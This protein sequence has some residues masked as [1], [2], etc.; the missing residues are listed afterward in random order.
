LPFTTAYHTRYPEY[1]A[2]RWPI[3]TWA[4]YAGLR[5]F[6]GAAVRTFVSSATLEAQLKSHGFSGLH[7]WCR[8]VDLARFKPGAAHPLLEGLPRPVMACVG[9]V[10]VEKNLAAF[11]ALPLPG[12]KLVIGDGPQLASLR[13]TYPQAR[14]TGYRAGAELAQLL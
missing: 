14:F 10:A 9:R 7:R 6:H 4:S 3:P 2:A 1:L 11:L 12:T 5:V 13:A 8:G